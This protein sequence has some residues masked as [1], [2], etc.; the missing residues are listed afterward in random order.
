MKLL[1]ISPFDNWFI[2]YILIKS[3][4][5][6]KWHWSE[7]QVIECDVPIIIECLCTKSIV[8]GEQKLRHCENHVFIEEIEYHFWNSNVWPMPVHK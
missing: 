8:K 5:D 2:V 4:S 3:S 7:E 6:H 1:I